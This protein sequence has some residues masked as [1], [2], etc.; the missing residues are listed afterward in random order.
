MF[1]HLAPG[2][3]GTFREQCRKCQISF[4]D[5]S[6]LIVLSEWDQ[7]GYDLL[8]TKADEEENLL[9]RVH[10]SS[11]KGQT[12]VCRV[13]ALQ[14]PSSGIVSVWWS[15]EAFYYDVTTQ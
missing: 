8:Q 6:G 15:G 5:N 4:Y 12:L 7:K 3:A 10:Q 14:V 2:L 13:V 9:P 1:L 11:G